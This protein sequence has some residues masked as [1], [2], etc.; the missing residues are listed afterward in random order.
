[1]N[2]KDHNHCMVREHKNEYIPWVEHKEQ[3]YYSV[4]MQGQGQVLAQIHVLAS[5]SL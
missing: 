1:M 4:C 3:I 2:Q 5:H